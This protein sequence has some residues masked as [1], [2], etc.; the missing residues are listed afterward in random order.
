MFRDVAKHVTEYA[1][2]GD[3]ARKTAQRG[4]IRS[5]MLAAGGDIGIAAGAL[6]IHRNTIA[7]IAGEVGLDWE[8]LKL[9]AREKAADEK[10][11]E[12]A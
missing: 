9:E 3:E 4:A 7:R 2:I 11:P 10:S 1:A 8:A 5:A 12:P 6:G